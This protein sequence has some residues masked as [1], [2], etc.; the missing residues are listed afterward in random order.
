MMSNKWLENFASRLNKT[1]DKGFQVEYDNM[2]GAMMIAFDDAPHGWILGATP[3]WEGANGV[4]MQAI[5]EDGDVVDMDER[6][7]EIDCD[8]E[9]DIAKYIKLVNEAKK[10]FVRS[11][12]YGRNV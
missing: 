11:C 1:V 2:S 7:F 6:K 4:P 12:E 10:D 5:S 3:F 9:S 8:W